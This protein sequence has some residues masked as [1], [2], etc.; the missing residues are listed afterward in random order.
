[1]EY[2]PD[3]KQITGQGGMV[4]AVAPKSIA[5]ELG[6]VPGD[7]IVS[8]NGQRLRDVIDYRFLSAEEQLTLL[9]RRDNDEALFEVEKD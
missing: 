9:V 1:M 5:E 3:L 6:I 7:I 2:Q 4:S 8:I